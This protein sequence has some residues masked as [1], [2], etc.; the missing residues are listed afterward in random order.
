MYERERNG[1]R[2]VAIKESRSIV[3]SILRAF[4]SRTDFPFMTRDTVAIDVPDSRATSLIVYMA[5]SP[6]RLNLQKI[7]P[8]LIL[9]DRLYKLCLRY[10][11]QISI[12]Q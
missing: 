2:E 3:S 1:R 8:V 9:N 11:I 12:F 6:T 10:I 4:S 7:T 5:K